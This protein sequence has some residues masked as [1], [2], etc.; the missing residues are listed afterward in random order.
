MKSNLNVL[1]I[2]DRATAGSGPHRNVVTSLN[3]LVARKDIYVRLLTG[4]VDH[5]EP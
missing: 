5:S 4:Q 1:F 3:A 2:V